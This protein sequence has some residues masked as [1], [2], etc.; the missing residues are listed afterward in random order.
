MDLRNLIE[1][2]FDLRRLSK[3]LD[4]LGHPARLWAAYQWTHADMAA[5]WE[6]AKGF[7]P[8]ALDDFVP[9]TVGPLM[10]VIHHGKN[11]L[12]AFQFF[13]KRFCRPKQPPRDGTKGSLLGLNRQAISF[14]TG[15]G[16]FVAHPATDEGEV[17]VD[18][19]MVPRE[20][21]ETW[22]PIVPSSARLGRFIYHGT[23]DV[24]RGISSHVT[25][26]RAKR[27]RGWMDAWFILVREDAKPGP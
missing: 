16:Y 10:E 26:G 18:Y 7:R 14:V 24:M 27:K 2:H 4:E 22:P 19:T 9:P 20:R 11:S 12:P 1:T 8:I 17:D 13:Q 25:I 23:I 21:P 6:G 15:P 5:L 3:D